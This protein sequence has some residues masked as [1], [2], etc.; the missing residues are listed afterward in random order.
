MIAQIRPGALPQWLAE[1][2]APPV[3]LDVR[4]LPELRVA[5]VRP[6]GFEL[7][8]I[9]MS[10]LAGR[11]DELDPDRPTACLCHHGVRSQQVAMYLSRSGFEQVVNI[12]GG[13]DAWSAERD[14]AIPRY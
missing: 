13:I 1:Q 4:E 3:V 14:P 10:E 12:A 7:V 8:T 11:L 5:A 9:P 2:T 6:E